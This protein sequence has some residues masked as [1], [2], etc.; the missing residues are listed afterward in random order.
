MENFIKDNAK[1][2]YLTVIRPKLGLKLLG[3]KELLAYKDLFYFMVARNIKAAY[4][5]TVLGFSWAI[6]QP[7]IQIL[8]F[9]IIFGKVAKVPTEG[10]PYS[11]FTA[12]AIIPWTYLSQAMMG[13]SQSLVTNKQILAKVYFPRFIYPITP[14]LAC[15]VNFGISFLILMPILFYYQVKPTL[16]LLLLPIFFL[17]LASGYRLLP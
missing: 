12:V 15:L 7:L 13:S 1:D 10:I 6:L 9:T 16:N 3:L 11:L 14:V 17:Q 2:Q 8:L 4:A 5:Q